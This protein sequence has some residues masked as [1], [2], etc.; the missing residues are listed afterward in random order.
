VLA[1]GLTFA[2][3]I[4]RL[5]ERALATVQ[6][7]LTPAEWIAFGGSVL[8]FTWFE[9]YRALHRRFVPAVVNRAFEVAGRS[10]GVLGFLAAPL[11]SLSLL[12]AGRRELVRA[13]VSV[14][15]IVLAVL[16]V[17]A[18]PSPWRGIVD[19][20]VSSALLLG[21]CSMVVRFLVQAAPRQD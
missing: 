14:A 15:L 13:W 17:R 8:V 1:I 21:L 9:G 19:A 12:D 10:R 6:E 4:H 5:G 20:G 18:L 16:V 7:G 3:A 11:R 2:E